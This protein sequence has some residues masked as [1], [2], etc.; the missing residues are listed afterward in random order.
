M[1]SNSHDLDCC[2]LLRKTANFHLA[3]NKNLYFATGPDLPQFT[4]YYPLN[5]YRFTQYCLFAN[6]EA[7]FGHISHHE[8]TVV[9]LSI[10]SK[11][12]CLLA[13]EKSSSSNAFDTTRIGCC[14]YFKNC[15]PYDV[16][17]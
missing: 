1:R 17:N 3:K 7:Q 9:L 13:F 12:L 16:R 6:K 8:L 11:H 14:N 2:F 15:K 10:N 5:E 4:N